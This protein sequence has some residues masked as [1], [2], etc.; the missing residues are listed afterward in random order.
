MEV[1]LFLVETLGG[2]PTSS[3]L[4]LG[5]GLWQGLRQMQD[6]AITWS[7]GKNFFS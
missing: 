6:P 3:S 5:G 7:K 2:P 1:L 4:P